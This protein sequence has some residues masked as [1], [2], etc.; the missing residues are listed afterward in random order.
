L[1]DLDYIEDISF[2]KDLKIIFMTV[3]KIF[4]RDDIST[5]GMDTAEDLGDYLLR[6]GKVSRNEYEEN[7]EKANSLINRY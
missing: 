5:E 7:Q 3:A 2:F 4:K 1:L 6:I